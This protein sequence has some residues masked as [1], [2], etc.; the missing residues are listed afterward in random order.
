MIDRI[1]DPQGVPADDESANGTL[2]LT[3]DQESRADAE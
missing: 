3:N 1:G 2:T